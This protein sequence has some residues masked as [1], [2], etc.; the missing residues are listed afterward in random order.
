[1]RISPEFWKLFIELAIIGLVAAKSGHNILIG[2]RT[3]SKVIEHA[4]Y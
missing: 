2:Y 4:Q 1:M 3:V